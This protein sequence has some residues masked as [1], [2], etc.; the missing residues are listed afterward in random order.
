M[1]CVIITSK[2]KQHWLFRAHFVPELLRMK[3]MSHL[4][5]CV[6]LSHHLFLISL[7]SSAHS[8][9][10][11][12]PIITPSEPLLQESVTPRL[13]HPEI[14]NRPFPPLFHRSDVRPRCFS[15][16]SGISAINL[17]GHFCSFDVSSRTA[18]HTVCLRLQCLPDN[19][20]TPKWFQMINSLL[21]GIPFMLTSHS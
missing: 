7:T 10:L 14:P 12:C 11:F 18:A 6:G 15:R 19:H 9:L 17:T 8:S 21:A 4:H 3:P 20:N 1:T 13:H 16:V 2:S 5:G